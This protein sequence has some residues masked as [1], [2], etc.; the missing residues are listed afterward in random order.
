MKKSVLTF[1]VFLFVTSF[2][3]QNEISSED[4]NKAID[5]SAKYQKELV[6]AS[7]P[8][9]NFLL[10]YE[11]GNPTQA[12]FDQMLNQMGIMDEVQNDN[13]GLTKEDA[14]KIIDTYI[15]ADQGKEVN[16]DIDQDKKEKILEYLNQLEQGKK[17]AAQIFG[18]FVNSGELNRVAGEVIKEIQKV[19]MMRLHISY[20]DFRKD[21]LKNNPNASET[22]IKKAYEKLKKQLRF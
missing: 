2:Y 19:Q 22:D 21:V 14:F 20:D 12:D 9:M 10:K 4:V 13:S 15:K 17:D 1:L 7:A 5:K 18:Q 6:K 8:M 11:N 16:I 3:A